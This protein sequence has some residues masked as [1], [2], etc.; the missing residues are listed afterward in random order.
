M[1]LVVI[2]KILS[3]IL[4]PLLSCD[5][6]MELFPSQCNCD[7]EPLR[8][9][10]PSLV[11]YQVSAHDEAT[12]SS[13]T[14]QTNDGPVTTN[15]ASLPFSTTVQLAEGETIELIAKGNPGNGSIILTY[16]VN[17]SKDTQTMLSSSVS[18]VWILKEGACQ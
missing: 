3:F 4:L 14:Y 16:E 7:I 13:I 18:K 8:L 17:D 11:T 1:R 9:T 10:Q 12:V 2:I 15:Q 5:K 6:N